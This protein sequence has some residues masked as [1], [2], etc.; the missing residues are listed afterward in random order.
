MLYDACPTEII[1]VNPSIIT[2][3]IDST[4]YSIDKI[5]PLDLPT[6]CTVF[7]SDKIIKKANRYYI[8]DSRY[9]KTVFV[10]D[11][12]GSFL[13][14]LGKKGHAKDEY[15]DG[16]KN[17]CVDNNLNVYIYERNSARI[18]Q[19][20]AKGKCICVKRFS[21]NVPENVA[22]TED[23][24]YICTFDGEKNGDGERLTIYGKNLEFK[25][26][27]MPISTTSALMYNNSLYEYSH[28][29][30]YTP[31]LSDSVIVLHNKELSKVIKIDFNGNFVPKDVLFDAVTDI[32]GYQKIANIEGVH[33]IEKFENTD[34][35]LHIEYNFNEYLYHYL[36]DKKTGKTYNSNGYYFEGLGLQSDYTLCEENLI[37]TITDEQL[38][39]ADEQ[40]SIPNW[41]ECYKH[42]PSK[43][44]D[45]IDRKYKAPLLVVI[46]IR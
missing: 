14:Q 24:D 8:M 44:R 20:D 40:R 15:I 4:H 26:S 1:S 46:K 34:N 2:N 17:F 10:F 45:I 37:Y 18:F 38:E 33:W 32:K 13:Y 22:I 12:K 39:W 23:C 7:S 36:K 11:E 19:Y 25:K 6:S 9:N 35:L 21:K 43:M 41:K 5:I 16:P 42:T 30:Y 28:Y 29:M 3:P 27:Y 31:L